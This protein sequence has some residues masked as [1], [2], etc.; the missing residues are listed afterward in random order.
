MNFLEKISYFKNQ[1]FFSSSIEKCR[2][3][4]IKTFKDVS[5]YQNN[6]EENLEILKNNLNKPIN[7]LNS[8]KYAQKFEFLES[9]KSISEEINLISTAGMKDINN[10]LKIKKEHLEDFTISL[11]GRT[12]AGKSTLRETL[13][14]DD[15]GDCYKWIDD[16]GFSK[17]RVKLEKGSSIGKGGQRTTRDV[18]EYRWNGLRLIDTPGIDAYKGDEDTSKANKVVDQSDIILFLVTDNSVQQA[19]FN[20]MAKLKKINKHFIV[21]LNVKMDITDPDD[22]KYYLKKPHKLFDEDVINGHK[23]HIKNYVSNNLS[24]TNVNIIAI[25]ALS[26]YLSKKEEYAHNSKALWDLSRIDLLFN[27]IVKEINTNGLKRRVQTLFEGTIFFVEDILEKLSEYKNNLEKQKIFL[28]KRR[29]YIESLFDNKKID[30][31]KEIELEIKKIFNRLKEWIPYFIDNYVKKQ[32][33]NSNSILES[34]FEETSQEAKEKVG[35]LYKKI[36]S[37]LQEELREFSRQFEYDIKNINLSNISI[38]E[39]SKSKNGKYIQIIGG[40]GSTLVI[41]SLPLLSIPVTWPIVA[42]VTAV[43]ALISWLGSWFNKKANQEHID[44]VRKV[45]SDIIY[46]INDTENQFLKEVKNII[47]KNLIV[48]TKKDIIFQIDGFNKGLNTVINELEQSEKVFNGIIELMKSELSKSI[49]K[50]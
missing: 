4:S 34:R 25:H 18:F 44:Q 35:L 8:N 15:N 12:R 14:Y 7:N 9:L 32:N 3:I 37:D 11:F 41:A 48:N 17:K 45:Q 50:L 27:D 49:S 16:L 23:V 6:I 5:K 47:S 43:G 40:L 22:L 33:K 28:D 26:A 2:N 31:T 10:S 24:I 20:E 21:M 39:I 30:Y 36:A 13:T 29:K 19:E 42:I 46:K 1:L 38:N